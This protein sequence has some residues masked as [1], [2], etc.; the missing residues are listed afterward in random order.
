MTYVIMRMYPPESWQLACSLYVSHRDSHAIF[1]CD[2]FWGT[3]LLLG[4]S[5]ST[6]T[7]AHET[8]V[9]FWPEADLTGSP[10]AGSLLTSVYD[11]WRTSKRCPPGVLSRCVVGRVG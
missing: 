9:R 8:P 3:S 5:G 10:S 1:G 4:K 7:Y 2:K 11:P 6:F